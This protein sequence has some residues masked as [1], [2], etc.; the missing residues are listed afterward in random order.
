MCELRGNKSLL[1]FAPE[2]LPRKRALSDRD[3]WLLVLFIDEAPDTQRQTHSCQ[4]IRFART[5]DIKQRQ[6]PPIRYSPSIKIRGTN[7]MLKK[8][9]DA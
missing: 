4:S 8:R 1:N 6:K 7:W 2:N 3:F 5:L 9:L